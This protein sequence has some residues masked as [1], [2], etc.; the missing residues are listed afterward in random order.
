MSK[1]QTD[2]IKSKE[3]GFGTQQF[4]GNSR[5]LNQDGTFNVK[6]KGVPSFSPD[7][8]YHQLI[9]MSWFKFLFLVLSFY[10]V[11]NILFAFV[12]FFI[13]ADQ[14]AG[15]DVNSS[16]LHQFYECF[17]FS[18]Q[19]LTT[20]G[21]G[22][23]SPL[24]FNASLIASIESMVGVLCFALITG[25]LYGRFSRPI[26]NIAYSSN[27]LIAPYR[28][29]NGLMIRLANRR[30]AQ[31]LEAEAELAVSMKNESGNGRTFLLLELE[32]TKINFFP[33]S[34]TIVHP[35]DERSP[36]Y[37]FT[38]EDYKNRDVE[39]MLLFK[40]FDES[41]SQ[42]VYSRTSYKF[43]EV[44]WNAKFISIIGT[45]A[46]TGKA[47]LDIDHINEFEKVE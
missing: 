45:D 14:L 7:N 13:G 36:L 38:E 33:L 6:R 16:V 9:S 43:N 5:A 18:S 46:A 21:Y 15:V 37:G 44:V 26:A 20:V 31:L 11:V 17:F 22:R 42:T 8:L 28:T 19:S 25:L 39:L 32:R 3:L 29:I 40:A 12:Y 47:T 27:A 35:L 34:W 30:N 24:H 10:F 1:A 4:S 2:T 41:F 23:I